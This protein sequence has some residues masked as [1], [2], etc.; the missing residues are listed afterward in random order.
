MLLGEEDR[1]RAAGGEVASLRELQDLVLGPLADML[2]VEVILVLKPSTVDLNRMEVVAQLPTGGS[3]ACAVRNAGL[4][5]A[6]RVIRKA[7][8]IVG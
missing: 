7:G 8:V 5:V 3:T 1:A 6:Q 4:V 2:Y